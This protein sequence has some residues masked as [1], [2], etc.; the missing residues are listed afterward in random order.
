MTAGPGITNGMSAMVA[1]QQNQSP[2]VVLGEPGGRRAAG[3]GRGAVGGG[4]R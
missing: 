3:R 2:M 1:A 4:V